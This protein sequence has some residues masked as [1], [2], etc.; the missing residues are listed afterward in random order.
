MTEL[1]APAT[2]PAHQM[3]QAPSKKS[4]I[5]HAIVCAKSN[6]P[7]IARVEI[8]VCNQRVIFP[9]H[10]APRTYTTPTSRNSD[11]VSFSLN[12]KSRLP[13]NGK[14]FQMTLVPV[15]AKAVNNS[16]ATNGVVLPW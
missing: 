6:T 1:H 2:P 3:T 5:E 15:D 9:E 10:N 4:G 14:P 11:K 8:I 13:I 16:D 12:P 7:I